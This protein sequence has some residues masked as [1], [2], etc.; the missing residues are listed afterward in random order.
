MFY[1]GLTYPEA[2]LKTY[3]QDQHLGYVIQPVLLSFMR[4]QAQI[5]FSFVSATDQLNS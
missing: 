5:L 4:N 1:T 3:F 2:S